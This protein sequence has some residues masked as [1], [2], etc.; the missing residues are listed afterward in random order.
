M[1]YINAFFLVWIPFHQVSIYIRSVAVNLIKD[2][3]SLGI[4]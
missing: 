2:G 4:L 3:A 1:R